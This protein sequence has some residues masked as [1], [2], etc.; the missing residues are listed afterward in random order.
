MIKKDIITIVNVDT[1]LGY[2]IAFRFL[3]SKRKHTTIRLVCHETDGLEELENLGGEIFKAD[4]NNGKK[5]KEVLNGTQLLLIIP[6]YSKSR[7]R[8]GNFVLCNAKASG[9]DYV[10]LFS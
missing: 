2:A 10:V 6:D 9:V 8:H 3:E 1:L 5:I 7:L 4:Y